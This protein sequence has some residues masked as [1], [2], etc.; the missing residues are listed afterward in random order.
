MGRVD[1]TVIK[2]APSLTHANPVHPR[3]RKEGFRL[4]LRTTMVSDALGG[5]QE[6][7]CN[8]NRRRSTNGESRHD[9]HTARKK[10]REKAGE[11]MKFYLRDQT[12]RGADFQ[13]PI[14]FTISYPL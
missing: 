3:R 13:T 7:V 4:K 9:I 6:H 11:Q 1:D 14:P 8:A 10:R 12:P 2:N 5:A